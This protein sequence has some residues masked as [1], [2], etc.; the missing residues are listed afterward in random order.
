MQSL[1]KKTPAAGGCRRAAFL[2]VPMLFLVA[3]CAT[4][5]ET[6]RG[7]DEERIERYEDNQFF[8]GSWLGH[9]DQQDD[10]N[11]RAPAWPVDGR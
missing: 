5:H 9:G 6:R 11:R 2:L 7:T 3:G 1:R 8:Y 4:P 10:V